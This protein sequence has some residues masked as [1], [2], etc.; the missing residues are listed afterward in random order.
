ASQPDQS[1]LFDR[2]SPL[3]ERLVRDPDAIPAHYRRGSG[4]GTRPHHG[5]YLLHRSPG[6]IITSVVWA[7]GEFVGPHDHHTWAMIGVL[8][9]GIQEMRFRRVDDRERED[10]AQLVRDRAYLVHSG[11]VSL[12]IPDQDEIHQL[13]NF[14]DRPTVEVHVYGDNLYDLL[15]CSYNLDTG[16]IRRFK[17]GRWDNC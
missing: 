14:S 8:A 3:L 9:N 11:E 12:L 5:S 4:Q 17:S 6:L 7:P 2:G 13:N 16:E 10:R 15:R 1:R